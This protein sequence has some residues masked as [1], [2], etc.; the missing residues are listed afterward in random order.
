MGKTFEEIMDNLPKE[1]RARIEKRG[2][3]KLREY[4][5]MQDIRKA[6]AL[7]QV[8]I[9]EKLDVNQENISRLEKRSDMMLST[10][11]GYIEALGGKL[12]I[13]VD[14]QGQTVS[15]M[16]LIEDAQEDL[17][18]KHSPQRSKSEETHV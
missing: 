11:N 5:T 17:Q 9:A 6:V 13:T 18:L 15:L 14:I 10:L 3:E 12:N 7:T 1:R 8:D 16:G 4:M 2:A